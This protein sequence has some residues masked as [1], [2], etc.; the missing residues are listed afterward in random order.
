MH[1]AHEVNGSRFSH[2]TLSTEEL[3]ALLPANIDTHRIYSRLLWTEVQRGEEHEW[4]FSSSIPKRLPARPPAGLASGHRPGNHSADFRRKLVCEPGGGDQ[5]ERDDA[6]DDVAA[7]GFQ[8]REIEA[9]GVQGQH[10]DGEDVSGGAMKAVAFAD[11]H[12]EGAGE[13]AKGGAEDAQNEE[14]ES[15]ASTSSGHLPSRIRLCK[16]DTR[17][18]TREFHS[19]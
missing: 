9:A 19:L 16:V 10:R 7:L 18:A 5:A 11:D 2:V 1:A 17:F 6:A 13:Q 14:W 3:L 15:H 12:G 8:D 4:L